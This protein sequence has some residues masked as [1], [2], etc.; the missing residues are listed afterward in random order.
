MKKMSILCWNISN[1]SL[2]RAKQQAVWLSRRS[3]NIFILTEAKNSAGCRFLESYFKTLRCDVLFPK[4]PDKDYAVMIISKIPMKQTN[5]S[6]SMKFLSPRIASAEIVINSKKVEIIGTYVPSRNASEQKIARKKTFLE[7][8]IAV[9]NNNPSNSERLFC[10]DLN[11]LEP[12]HN[13]HYSFF[14]KWEYDF[15]KSLENYG[16]TDAFRKLNPAKMDYS[17][18]GRTGD[19]YRYDHCFTTS[20]L[21]KLLSKSYYL[22]SPRE[23]RLSDHA[24]LITEFCF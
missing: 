1:P 7:E 11:I 19:G 10:G 3:E 9:F 8:L 12:N 20:G 5:F 14:K 23:K 2:E 6:Q 22:H 18:I 21:T 4:P 17:W 24:A 16:L 15:Y 13:P